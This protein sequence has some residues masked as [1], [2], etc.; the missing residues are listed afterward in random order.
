MNSPLD[1]TNKIQVGSLTDECYKRIKQDILTGKLGWGERLNVIN[2]AEIYGISRSPVIKAIERLAM[3]QLIQIIPNV[4]SFVHIPTKEDIKEVTEIRLMLETTMCRLAYEKNKGKLL[5][6][7]ADIDSIIDKAAIS[8]NK[9]SFEAFIDY[10]HA[11]HLTFPKHANN[12]RMAAY[13]DSIR[14]QIE[15]FRTKTYYKTYIDLAIDRHHGII[16]SLSEGR[17]E[18]AICMLQTHISEVEQE[19]IGSIERS[20]TVKEYK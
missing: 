3:E 17:L 10:D 4:G 20:D 6:D 5:D 8:D 15:L 9:I 7:L 11:F 19:I 1:N 13:Y 16:K 12:G 18:D 14:N 2:L